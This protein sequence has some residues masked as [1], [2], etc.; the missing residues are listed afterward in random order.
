MREWRRSGVAYVHSLEDIAEV[1]KCI[2]FSQ[3]LHNSLKR[4]SFIEIYCGFAGVAGRGR[5]LGVPRAFTNMSETSREN[6]AFLKL[7]PNWCKIAVFC[8]FRYRFMINITVFAISILDLIIIGGMFNLLVPA[9]S[10]RLWVLIFGVVLIP[11]DLRSPKISEMKRETK[12]FANGQNH[13]ESAAFSLFCV[14]HLRPMRSSSPWAG[15]TTCT[16]CPNWRR[17]GS[18]APSSR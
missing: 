7:R 18:A 2:N 14:F 8:V 12:V 4:H 17:R 6:V 5:A 16:T 11:L 10:A 3:I 13:Y 9:L 15:W 1:Q